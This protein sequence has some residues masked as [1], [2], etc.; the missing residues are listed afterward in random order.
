MRILVEFYGVPRS[1]AGRD[2]LEVRGETLRHVLEQVETVCPPLQGFLRDGPD[3][4]R[5]CLVSVNGREFVQ[6][7]NR[8]LRPDD[9]V[10]IMSAD[11][12]G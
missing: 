9:R 5:H 3:L 12:G 4:S 8:R 7:L 6:D 11:V 2:R 10:L 1:R